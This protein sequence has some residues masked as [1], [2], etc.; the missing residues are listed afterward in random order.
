MGIPSLAGFNN[1]LVGRRI[2][3][4]RPNWGLTLAHTPIKDDMSCR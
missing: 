1:L 4:N 3:A 2:I